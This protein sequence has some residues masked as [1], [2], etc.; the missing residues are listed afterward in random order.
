[1]REYFWLILSIDIHTKVYWSTNQTTKPK[2]LDLIIKPKDFFFSF[3]V[4][5]D[6]KL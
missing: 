2:G 5:Y 4:L 3:P 1:M 6:E